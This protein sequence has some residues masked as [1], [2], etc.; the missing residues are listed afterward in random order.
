MHL[1]RITSALLFVLCVVGL[2][3][4]AIAGL[5]TQPDKENVVASRL[6]GSW[7]PD[8][9]LTKYLGGTPIHEFANLEDKRLTFTEDAA[10]VERIPTK[11]HPFLKE[12][13][14]FLAGQMELGDDSFPYVLIT[15]KGNPHVVI[16]MPRDGKPMDNAESFNVM[17]PVGK[18]MKNDM[19][20]IGGDM[21]NQPFSAYKRAD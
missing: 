17:L 7:T 10:V 15:H 1:T 12:E 4:L 3:T 2:S 20:F 13:Q 6:V 21:N 9:A 14:I 8:Q 16:F 11:F 18:E 19:L 5:K